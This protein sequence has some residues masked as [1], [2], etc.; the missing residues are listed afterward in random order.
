MRKKPPSKKIKKDSKKTLPSDSNLPAIQPKEQEIIFNNNEIN[1]KR[2]EPIT[3]KAE[4]PQID[5]QLTQKRG[6]N[7]LSSPSPSTSMQSSVK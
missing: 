2:E 5:Y 6:I 4:L 1:V 7:W 3:R